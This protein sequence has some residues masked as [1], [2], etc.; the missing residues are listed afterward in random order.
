MGFVLLFL[1]CGF[2]DLFV[3]FWQGN[4]K[5]PLNV[6]LLYIYVYTRT[7]MYNH[8]HTCPHLI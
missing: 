4:G 8:M 3:D 2:L 7:F 6:N 5:H 1:W